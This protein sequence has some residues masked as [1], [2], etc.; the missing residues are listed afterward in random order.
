VDASLFHEFKKNYGTTIVTG[1]GRMYGQQIGIVANNGI[2]FSESSLK[3]CMHLRVFWKRAFLMPY[4]L[5]LMHVDIFFA[6]SCIEIPS[7]LYFALTIS[8][9][10]FYCI[11]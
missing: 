3:V 10:G 7:S 5:L 8:L 11:S 1:F 2:L 9:F 4:E 6:S